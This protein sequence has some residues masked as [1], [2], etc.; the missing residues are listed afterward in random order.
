[1]IR[2][3]F[4]RHRTLS[5]TAAALALVLLTATVAEFAPRMLPHSRLSARSGPGPRQGHRHRQ[6]GG[7]ALLDLDDRHL[8]T[9]TITGDHATLGRIPDVSARAR[10]DDIRLTGHHSS[11]VAHTHVDVEVPPGPCKA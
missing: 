10:L 11:T 9:V 3:A 2:S 8:G 7:P 6:R 1:M 5:V 4:R